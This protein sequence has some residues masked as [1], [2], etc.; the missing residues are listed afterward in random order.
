MVSH[1]PF[2]LLKISLVLCSTL[3][4]MQICKSRDFK[5]F[6]KMC[7]SCKTTGKVTNTRK[8]RSAPWGLPLFC[9]SFFFSVLKVVWVGWL[10]RQDT[11]LRRWPLAGVQG[12]GHGE[13]W[14]S[15]H[16]HD[17]ITFS[18]QAVSGDVVPAE[19]RLAGL[20]G[21]AGNLW[22]QGPASHLPV[23]DRFPP[24]FYKSLNTAFVFEVTEKPQVKKAGIKTT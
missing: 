6:G 23:R 19:G 8:S 3:E 4:Y 14:G 24:L 10:L 13:V 12:W 9:F 5:M 11:P 20:A 16:V 2:C 7:I 18:S 1:S 17:G 22:G 15:R 21:T